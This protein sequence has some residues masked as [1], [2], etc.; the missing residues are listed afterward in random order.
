[1]VLIAD[2]DPAQPV[3]T[4][5]AFVE[6]GPV[7][8]GGRTYTCPRRSATLLVAKSPI[9][10]GSYA[11]GGETMYH[12]TDENLNVTSISDSHFDNYHVFRS[13]MRILEH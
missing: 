6:Y 11:M 4:A 1:M 9:E 10:H 8:I 13:E 12:A 7:E 2:A 5:N 3:S